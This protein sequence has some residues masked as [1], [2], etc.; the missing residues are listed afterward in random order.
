MPEYVGIFGTWLL[1]DLACHTQDLIGQEE[2][3]KDE[4]HLEHLDH[5]HHTVR[6]G[7]AVAASGVNTAR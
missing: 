2:V 1:P 7:P 3:D 5:H 6:V 4:D